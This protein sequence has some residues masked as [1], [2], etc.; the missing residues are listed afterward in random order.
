MTLF[1]LLSGK[2]VHLAKGKKILKSEEYGK[3]ISLQEVKEEVEK[4]IAELKAQATQDCERLKKEAEDKGFQEALIRLN[5]HIL[6][7]DAQIKSLRI[8]LMQKILPLSLVAAKKIVAKELEQYPDTIVD[9]VMKVLQ[10]VLQNKKVIIYVNKQDKE[11][12]EENKAK[13]KEQFE[14]LESLSIQENPDIAPGG[15]IIE[16]ETG[17][18][19]ASLDNQWRALE[20]AF[21]R[22]M[23]EKI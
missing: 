19:N 9:I 22:Y 14:R 18:I 16:T 13:I 1:T 2:S 17:I 6:H 3:L 10:S 15:C 8:E 11:I 20:G 7:F 12:I 4:E 5:E 21:T 23:K